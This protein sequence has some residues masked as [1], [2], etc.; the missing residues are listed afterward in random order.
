M[1]T[2]SNLYRKNLSPDGLIGYGKTQHKLANKLESQKQMKR[3]STKLV[4]ST[5][6]LPS[7]NIKELHLALSYK[8]LGYKVTD[9]GWTSITL[10]KE[11]K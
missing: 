7:T 2:M 3:K 5:I 6:T 8:K 9:L 11:G 4:K 1:N 10:E